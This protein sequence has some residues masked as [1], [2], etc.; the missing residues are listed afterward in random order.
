MPASRSPSALSTVWLALVGGSIVAA[1]WTGRMEPLSDAVFASAS[2]AV[3]LAI[4]LVGTLAL[5]LGVVRV[6]ERAGLMAALARLVR[7]LMVRLF[8]DIPAEHPAMS[9]M[10]MN[11]SANALGMGNAATPLGL[12]A[13][14]ELDRLNPAKG[15][16]TDAMCLFLAI[17]TSSVTLVPITVMAARAAAGA[18]NPAAILVPTLLATLCSTAVAILA[19]KLLARRH[20]KPLVPPEAPLSEPNAAPAPSPARAGLGT[21]IFGGALLV[22]FLAAIP[23]RLW[24]DEAPA[25]LATE[26]LSWWLLPTL[27]GGLLLHGWLHGVRVY[28]AVTEG[29]VEGVRIAIRIVPFLVAIFVAIGMFRAS[30]AFDALVGVLEPALGLLGLPADVLPVAILRPLSGSGALAATTEILH[31]APNG[32]SAFLASTM[33]GSTETTFYVLA[34]YFGS[35]GIRRTRYALTAGLLADAAGVLSALLFC[36]LLS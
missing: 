1:A 15:T 2:S 30:G 28:E 11:L 13:M 31:Q 23:Y 25:T 26:M 24:T 20:R 8:P 22:A 3:T 14:A 21:R 34:V 17:N 29:A 27:L 10:V 12:K 33:Q 4:G 36:H 9:A 35:V 6:S 5:W 18:D 19:A 7:P 32:F 16:A